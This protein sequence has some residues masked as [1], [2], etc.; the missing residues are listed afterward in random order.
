VACLIEDKGPTGEDVKME[1]VWF[2][3]Q[4]QPGWRIAGI[5]MKVFPDLPAV[6]YNFEDMDDMQRKA[7][8]VE[9]EM[10]R[11]E[12]QAITGGQPP[13]QQTGNENVAAPPTNVAE[14]PD[15]GPTFTK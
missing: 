5:A 8:L 6:L 14:V 15:S 3:R 12:T 10:V 2:L 1:V 9:Q 4:E 11:R 7:E 13:A